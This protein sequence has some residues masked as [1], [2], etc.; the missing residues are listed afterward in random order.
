MVVFGGGKREVSK[1]NEEF[2]SKCI[3]ASSGNTWM[4]EDL[5]K[6]WVEKVLGKFSFGRRLLAWDSLSCQIMDSAKNKVKEI[7]A[8]MLIVPG[9]CTTYIQTPDVCWN[10]PFKKLVTERYKAWLAESSQEYTA[11]GNLKATPRRTI[12]EWILEAWKTVHI[13][14]IKSSFKSC[15]LNIAVDGSE[16]R[17]IHCFKEDQSCSA[18]LHR[19][20][21]TIDD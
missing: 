9:D 17:L 20:A 10:V 19:L 14:V 3:I 1:L 21:N 8:D 6:I 7:N 2:R 16:D 12:V 5:T 13:D 15:A 18:G 4:N 11:Q